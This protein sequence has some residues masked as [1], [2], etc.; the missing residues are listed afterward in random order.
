MKNQIAWLALLFWVMISI[1]GGCKKD[2]P[3]L[4]IK[5]EENIG[6]G[7][8]E[9]QAALIDSMQHIH[10]EANQIVLPDGQLLSQF[11]AE[12]QDWFSGL[13]KNDGLEGKSPEQIK[14]LLLGAFLERARQLTDRNFHYYVKEGID[15]PEQKGLAYVY[16]SDGIE[17]RNQPT[18]GECKEHLYGLDCS[19]FILQLVHYSGLPMGDLDAEGLS[20]P[21]NWENTFNSF[22]ATVGFKMEEIPDGS[23]LQSGD[24]IYWTK[25][26]GS[27]TRHI[28]IVLEDV[29]GDLKVHVSNGAKGP[30]NQ[31]KKNYGPTRGP[32]TVALNSKDFF[33]TK[34][35]NWI[36]LRIKVPLASQTQYK[37]GD[38]AFGGIIFYLDNTKKHGM[39]RSKEAIPAPLWPNKWAWD[40][41][42]RKGTKYQPVDIGATG[43]ALGDGLANTN[44][45]TAALGDGE[46]A[47]NACKKYAG[48][49]YNDWY[50]PSRDELKLAFQNLGFESKCV[51]W[52][53]SEIT[54][55]DGKPSIAYYIYSCVGLETRDDKKDKENH[56]YAVRNF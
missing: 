26:S 40:D 50:L 30:S 24:V 47:A 44:K 12:N 18:E 6:E 43:T 34:L 45:I 54:Y 31:C 46:Y 27:H 48:G 28:G 19:G 56:V 4:P 36:I 11:I 14:K 23:K 3:S 20:K 10:L 8:T 38:E 1:V 2:S 55:S 33:D 9:D 51:A 21:Q 39:V 52:T 32:T 37:I 13:G 16:G 29:N 35:A 5:Q 25:I 22:P 15:K 17:K 42:A 53:S 7:L 41:K 49:G